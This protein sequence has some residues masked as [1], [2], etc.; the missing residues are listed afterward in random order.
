M[1]GS[2]PPKSLLDSPHVT[3]VYLSTPLAFVSKLPKPL[4]L[5][6]SPLKV[7]AGAASLLWA[8]VY[9][10]ESTPEFMVIQ[11]SH[12]RASVTFT[13]CML[14]DGRATPTSEP[15]FDSDLASGQAGST[16]MSKQAHH[17]LAQHGLLGTQ[18]ATWRSESSRQAR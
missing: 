13:T 14:V 5:L 8:L 11:V 9:R 2:E 3:F 17:R 12:R 15:S 16:A 10:L 18:Y 1:I 7:L 6:M 4:F